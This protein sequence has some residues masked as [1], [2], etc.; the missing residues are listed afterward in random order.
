MGIM[1]IWEACQDD[2]FGT[3]D[4]KASEISFVHFKVQDHQ[5]SCEETDN[6]FKFCM[7]L[8]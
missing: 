4:V 1:I 8:L 6:I 5:T 2:R 3:I 7:P